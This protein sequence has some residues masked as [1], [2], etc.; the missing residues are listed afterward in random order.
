MAPKADQFDSRRADVEY[1]DVPLKWHP[2]SDASLAIEASRVNPQVDTLVLAMNDRAD[3]RPDD[4]ASAWD[5][6][7]SVL[8]DA[9]I[10]RALVGDEGGTGRGPINRRTDVDGDPRG[11]FALFEVVQVGRDE[12][13]RL[14]ATRWRIEAVGKFPLWT[15]LGFGFGRFRAPA[16]HVACAQVDRL[17][18]S[19]CAVRRD[20]PKRLR[21]AAAAC[22][23][24]R[25]YGRQDG[26]HDDQPQHCPAH[27]TRVPD[28]GSVLS[29]RSQWWAAERSCPS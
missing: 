1:L 13:D 22:P 14:S 12:N 27:V 6:F 17:S 2:H 26:H 24:R 7:I 23:R 15:F 25:T 16:W 9:G 19:R 21:S 8:I 20:T 4:M 28:T 18:I 5:P 11:H 10:T 29:G 3:D